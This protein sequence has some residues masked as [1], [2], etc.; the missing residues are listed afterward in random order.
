MYSIIPERKSHI[1]LYVWE[2][3]LI[4][5]FSFLGSKFTKRQRRVLKMHLTQK[6]RELF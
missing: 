6:R 1:V 5:L 3:G 2:P 4:G